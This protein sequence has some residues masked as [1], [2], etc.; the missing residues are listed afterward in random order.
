MKFEYFFYILIIISSP[1]LGEY[2]SLKT[3]LHDIIE[4]LFHE[5]ERNIIVT[6]HYH[7]NYADIYNFTLKL[8]TWKKTNGKQTTIL[9]LSK[10]DEKRKELTYDVNL[11]SYSAIYKKKW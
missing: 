2:I 1:L 7:T 4:R 11:L 3:V 9:C 5:A 10:H 6:K 8:G